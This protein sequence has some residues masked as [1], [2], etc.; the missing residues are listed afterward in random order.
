MAITKRP[1]AEATDAEKRQ[2]QIDNFGS[3]MRDFGTGGRCDVRGRN[4]PVPSYHRAQHRNG[5]G[6]GPLSPKSKTTGIF[7]ADAEMATTK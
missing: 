1:E 5:C 4:E 6:R 2:A 3:W 7:S